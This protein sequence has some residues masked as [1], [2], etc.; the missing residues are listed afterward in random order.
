MTPTPSAPVS[1]RTRT[2]ATWGRLAA[3]LGSGLVAGLCFPPTN[4][5]PLVLVALVPLL[6][7]WR[8]ARPAHAALYGFAF[9]VG[10]YGITI[11]WIRY[12]GTVAVV[13]LVAVM[14]A[15]IAVVGL[16]VA[17]LARRGVAS[18]LLTAAVWVL[19]EALRGRWPFGGFPWSDLGIAMHDVSAARAVASVGGALLLSFLVVAFNGFVLD[20]VLAIVARSRR[21]ASSGRSASASGRGRG[22]L[23]VATAAGG[24]VGVLAFAFVTDVTRFEPRVTGHLRVAMLQPDDEE[25][26]L[27]GQTDQLLT[28]KSLA[29]AD[30]LQGRYD[31]I[32]FPESALDTDPQ[33]DPALHARLAGI[34]AAHDSSLLVNARTPGTDGQVRN[35]NLLYDPDGRLQGT[36]SK[37]H[38]VPFGEYVPWRKELGFIRELR[39]IPYD[40][41]AGHRRQVFTV[42]G[43]PIGSVICFESAF[44]PLV[45]D[46][47]RDGAQA[48]IVSTNNRSYRRSGNSEQHLAL[49]QMRAAETARPV[50]QASVSG[51]SGV[52][53]PDGHVSDT[54]QLF[55][56]TTTSTT[57]ATTTGETLYVRFGDWIIV[58]SAV[59]VLGATVIAVVRTRRGATK[60]GDA[61]ATTPAA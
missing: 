61:T 36:Y 39:Q 53:D 25:L 41:Q 12:F 13:P 33:T 55:E 31:L 6:W 58:L 24:L 37:Q 10:C 38:L 27:A 1:T 44:G 30:R 35:T 47:V 2:R 34:A 11:A 43:R 19:L 29:L 50:L 48:I 18:P 51:I 59:A 57:I 46:Y 4:F 3:A 60:N 15:A 21:S 54:T 28:D 23:A 45:R 14:A 16:I 9:G 20:L 40:F 8:G 22:R 7:A 56:S 42:A 32:V 26:S 17:L 5:G 52:I 49:S